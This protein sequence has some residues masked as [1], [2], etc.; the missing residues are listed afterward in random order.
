[1]QLSRRSDY[2]L[3]ALIFLAAREEG[4]I[5]GLPEIARTAK[6]S[7]PFLAKILNT[8]VKKG[9]VRSYR[10]VRGGFALARP[11]AEINFLDIIEAVDGP[12]KVNLCVGAGAGC[13]MFR[14]CLLTPAMN[15]IQA[16]FRG[17]LRSKSISDALGSRLLAG[18]AGPRQA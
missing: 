15:H 3:R 10:G 7:R 12:M 4:Q 1:M 16:E 13:E 8:L 17:V 5:A 14:T 18:A 6:V 11:A 2:A 9:F